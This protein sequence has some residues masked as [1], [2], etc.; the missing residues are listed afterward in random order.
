MWFNA[1]RIFS[2]KLYSQRDFFLYTFVHAWAISNLSTLSPFVIILG[3]EHQHFEATFGVSL[4]LPTL[5]T[6]PWVALALIHFKF[7]IPY[8][9]NHILS[10]QSFYFLSA[11]YAWSRF[12]D[13]RHLDCLSLGYIC[14]RMCVHVNTCILVVLSQKPSILWFVLVLRHGFS[15]S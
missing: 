12:L 10:M 11:S 9:N 2:N 7:Y 3:A 1:L 6:K 4:R 13:T 5:P 8:F 15:L 14:V